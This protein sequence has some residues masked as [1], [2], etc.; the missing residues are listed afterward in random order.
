MN[1]VLFSPI[2][3]SEL[4]ALIEKVVERAFSKLIVQQSAKISQ[5]ETNRPMTVKEA[6]VFL[7]LA[8][9]TIY[10]LVHKKQIPNIKRGGRLYF[11]KSDLNKWL[12]E[13]RQKTA[14]EIEEEV[15]QHFLNMKKKIA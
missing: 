9:P 11:L 13:A 14:S 1:D 10:G 3:L 15:K 4:E 5:T 7:D 8:E 6:A 12:E 2:R